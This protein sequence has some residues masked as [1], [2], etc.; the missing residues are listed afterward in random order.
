[1]ADMDVDKRVVK[2][3]WGQWVIYTRRGAGP[4]RRHV[5]PPDVDPGAAYDVVIERMV[6]ALHREPLTYPGRVWMVH[7]DGVTIT[8]DAHF[9]GW[10]VEIRM[11]REAASNPATGGP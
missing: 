10:P 3:G 8:R 1:M 2:G 4:T 6:D 9:P 7:P 11:A 5:V